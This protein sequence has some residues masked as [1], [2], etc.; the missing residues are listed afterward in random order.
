MESVS[1]IPRK[2]AHVIPVR[3]LT[4]H[5]MPLM[6]T[7]RRAMRRDNST[8]DLAAEKYLAIGL[9]KSGFRIRRGV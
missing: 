2:K 5:D 7:L 6:R 4:I 1:L 8:M 9:R 3:T